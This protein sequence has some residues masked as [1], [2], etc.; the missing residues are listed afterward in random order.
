MN[1]DS[2]L[3]VNSP[4]YIFVSNN[5]IVL[6]SLAGPGTGKTFALKRRIARLISEG[7]DPKR[8]LAVTFTRTAASD[9]Q[10]E[11]LSLNI[12]GA[13]KVIAKTLHSLCLQLLLKRDIMTVTERYPRLMLTYEIK[14]MLK[15]LNKPEFGTLTDKEKRLRAFEAA[16]ARLQSDEPGY[17]LDEI[18]AEFER[19][20]LK[21]LKYHKAM[22]IGEVVPITLNYLK[23]NPESPE[24]NYYEHILVDE[25]Q[26]LN[27][28]E[29]ELIKA[30][31][32]SK[33]LVIVGDDNQSIYSFKYANPEG[34][35][36]V[37]EVY[38]DCY[39]VEFNECRRC[40]KIV[41]KLANQLIK[42]NA[43]RAS[44]DLL[45]WES[46][47]NGEVHIIQWPLLDNEISGVAQIVKNELDMK[48]INPE[49]ILI[50]TPRRH[51][52]YRIRD[53]LNSYNIPAKSY[54]RED[55]L[56]S[57]KVREV[58]SLIN[59]LAYPEDAVALRFLLGFGAQDGR[60]NQY[61]RL[62]DRAVEINCSIRQLLEKIESGIERIPNIRSIFNQYHKIKEELNYIK[63]LLVTD[64]QVAL[65]YFISNDEDESDFYEIKQIYLSAIDEIGI[66]NNKEEM[67]SWIKKIFDYLT[68]RISMPEAP[69]DA[70]HV[71]IMSLH[72]SKGLS[73]KLV[74]ITS[75]IEQLI[76]NIKPDLSDKE[77]IRNLEEQRRLFYV[78]LTRCKN[79]PGIYPGKLII[80]SCTG[81]P[82]K[83]AVKM[84]IPSKVNQIRRVY[85]SRFITELGREK[86]PTIA[87]SEFLRKYNATQRVY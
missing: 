58:Y 29:Q 20:I 52:G 12:S 79:D 6:H 4:A 83:E 61:K 43:N 76:P 49:D 10:N 73:S 26:D 11:I 22:L 31:K 23:N 80:S 16:W 67:E 8:I 42:N 21:W 27:R 68:S 25:Y 53:C 48:E 56:S 24:I 57:D 15:D 70:D 82:G 44:R 13:E 5:S 72:S 60:S 81:I 36:K 14:I 63:N 77:K 33:N 28:A 41:V 55:A 38:K 30:L 7:V 45:R 9:L 2:G 37:P 50:L 18:D 62:K 84:G 86:P 47:D 64:C 34:I 69:M 87:G 32:G 66:L 51:I 46:N 59:L 54:F 71:R 1:W 74:I 19:E 85:A 65:N 17:A 3:D 75:T 39:S 35:R 78:A 40:P